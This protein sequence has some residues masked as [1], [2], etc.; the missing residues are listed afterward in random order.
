MWFLLLHYRTNTF[1]RFALI[2]LICTLDPFTT[3]L[4]HKGVYGTHDF[5]LFLLDLFLF[6]GSFD[7]VC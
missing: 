3:A 6:L 5:L 4:S 7:D 2:E 1:T